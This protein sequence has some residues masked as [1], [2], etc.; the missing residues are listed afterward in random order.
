MKAP[1]FKGLKSFANI[2]AIHADT[3]AEPWSGP[4]DVGIGGYID[5]GRVVD[6]DDIGD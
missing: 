6:A 2:Y 4:V 5:P 1:L 3:I